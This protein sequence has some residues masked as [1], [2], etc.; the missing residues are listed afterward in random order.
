MC[1]VIT[2]IH[3]APPKA[4]EAIRHRVWLPFGGRLSYADMVVTFEIDRDADSNE[5]TPMVCVDTPQGGGRFPLRGVLL[6]HSDQV[7]V[8]PLA[9]AQPSPGAMPTSLLIELRAR[10]IG[11]LPVAV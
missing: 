8:I 4:T 11:A 3:P 5:V 6:N 10:C 9:I 1:Q 2:L 7:F